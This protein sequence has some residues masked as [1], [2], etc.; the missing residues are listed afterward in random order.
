M[1]ATRIYYLHPLL[2]GPIDAWPH[3]LDRAASMRFDTIAIAPPFATGRAGDLFLTADHDRF[4]ER[5]GGG[6]AQSG[7]AHFARE[8]RGRQLVPMLD[9]VIDR[10]ATEHAANG[11]ARWYRPD[12]SDELPDPRR[13]PQQPGVARLSLDGDLDGAVE[14][15]TRQFFGWVDAGIASFRCVRPHRVPAQFWRDL[16][17]AVRRQ[18]PRASFMASTLGVGFAETEALAEC[19]FD[20]VASCSRNWDYRA[21]EFPDAVN[22]L[23]HIAPVI[24]MPETPFDRRLS[25]GFHDTGKARRAARRALAFATSYGA[26]WMMPMGFEFGAARDMDGTRDRH[27][28]FA[29]LVAEAPFD[30]SAEIADANARH[31]TAC[32]RG[33]RVGPAACRRRRRRR[34]R[35]ARRGRERMAAAGHGRV[36]CSPMPASTTQPGCRWRRC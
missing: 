26:G 33:G 32:E 21:E 5:L 3:Q 8:C 36:S 25:R 29:R 19:G 28:D 12:S 9:V 17:T 30:L 27:E 6:D 10:V 1:P 23:A 24:A 34:P 18:H 7:L 16:I 22:R 35:S 11:L 14:W 15:W 31:A 20:L 13:A 2:G 4:D